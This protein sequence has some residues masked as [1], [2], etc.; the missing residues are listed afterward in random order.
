MRSQ[1]VLLGIVV[2][3]LVAVGKIK[4]RHAT[5]RSLADQIQLREILGQV[6]PTIA[7]KI[8]SILPSRSYLDPFM[9]EIP[10]IF[11]PGLQL[12]EDFRLRSGS[13]RH[14]HLNQY[15]RASGRTVWSMSG[16]AAS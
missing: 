6:D 16:E 11:A 14:P 12:D 4:T 13:L 10:H 2:Q 5:R 1:V 7:P 8:Q 3:V 9:A 15:A